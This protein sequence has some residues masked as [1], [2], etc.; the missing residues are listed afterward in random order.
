[1]RLTAVLPMA[2]RAVKPVA[3][4]TLAA[5]E[6]PLVK[7]AAKLAV[8]VRLTA[9]L[10]RLTAVLPM[11]KRVL[12]VQRPAMPLVLRMLQVKQAEMAAK[13]ALLM[14]LAAGAMPVVKLAAKLA[15]LVRP[16]AVL[17]MVKRA[18]M[19]QRPAMPLVLRMLQ[20]KL[21]VL[22]RLTAVMPMVDLIAKLAV[23]MRPMLAMAVAK[24]ALMAKQALMVKRALMVQRTAMPPFLRM[25][26]LKQ[27]GM[28]AKRALRMTL[29]AGAMPVVELAA[30]L[31]V[32]VKPRAVLPMARRALMVQRTAMPPLLRAQQAMKVAKMVKPV[33]KAQRMPMVKQAL[34]GLLASVQAPLPLPLMRLRLLPE[35]AV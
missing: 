22:V 18:L 5:A 30:K 29:A 26:Q 16:R 14:T 20:L 25:L 23:L 2:K 3:L 6:M 28:A 7:L 13:R 1:L 11:A 24:R 35:M 32:L 34:K 8:L 17:P 21:A 15:V 27:A 9:V 31:A 12:M 10:V 4:M 19:V 33:K